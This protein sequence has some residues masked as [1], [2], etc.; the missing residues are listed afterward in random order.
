MYNNYLHEKQQIEQEASLLS[1]TTSVAAYRKFALFTTN[2]GLALPDIPLQRHLHLFRK[3]VAN[4]QLCF[5]DEVHHGVVPWHWRGE[6]VLDFDSL[7]HRPAIIGTF[8]TGS[9][10]LINYL[11]AQSGVP[12]ALLVSSTVKERQ[13]TAFMQQ[14]LSIGGNS[15]QCILITAD[16]PMAGLHILR[17]VKNGRTVVGYLDGNRGAAGQQHVHQLPFLGVNV[18]VRIGLAHLARRAGIPFHGVLAIR[19]Q[20]GGVALW[21]SRSYGHQQDA[22]PSETPL[23]VTAAMYADLASIAREEPWQWDH[24]YYLH[25]TFLGHGRD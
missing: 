22:M 24:W 12:T 20:A 2:L 6:R 17:A 18:H 11:L 1:V 16:H 7:R 8:H 23:E 4:R 19:E 15:K 5:L 21:H 9:Y 10:R 13:G 25:E 14:G 3:A